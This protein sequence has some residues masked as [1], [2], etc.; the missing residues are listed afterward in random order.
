MRAAAQGGD[1]TSAADGPVR[2]TGGADGFGGVFGDVVRH[3]QGRQLA[4]G[5]GQIG[6][7]MDGASVDLAPESQSTR[8]VRT[9]NRNG[10]RVAGTSGLQVEAG[11][12]GG[13]ADGHRS[14]GGTD[15]VGQ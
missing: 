6:P 7:S 5:S 13:G 15:G 3:G 10:G 9:Y 1:G 12:V 4:A 11:Q 2:E 14:G 8:Q